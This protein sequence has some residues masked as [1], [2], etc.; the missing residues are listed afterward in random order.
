MKKVGRALL[1]AWAI[2]GFLMFSYRMVTGTDPGDP[3]VIGDYVIFP[4][5]DRTNRARQDQGAPR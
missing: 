1:A 2:A 5:G 4:A 3:I